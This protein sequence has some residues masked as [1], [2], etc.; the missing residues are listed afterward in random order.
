M[1]RLKIRFARG[2][3]GAGVGNGRFSPQAEG[4]REEP[5]EQ[6]SLVARMYAL[7]SCVLYLVG[8]EN[9]EKSNSVGAA[10]HRDDEK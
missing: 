10:F 6:C 3:I 8:T 5:V 1:G 2:W 4:G 7:R 9:M